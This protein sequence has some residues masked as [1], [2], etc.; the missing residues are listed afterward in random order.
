MP[1]QLHYRNTVISEIPE[2]WGKVLVDPQLVDIQS[3][4]ACAKSHAVPSGL[5]HLR[6]F[7]VTTNG[8][9]VITPDTVEIPSDFRQDLESY[10]LEAGDVLFNNTNSVELVGKTG[11]VRHAMKVAFSNHINRLRVKNSAQIDP[12]WLALALRNLQERGFFAA[13]C[14]KWIGQAGFNQTELAHVEIPLPNIEEQQRIVTRIE[15]LLA[16][17]REMRKLQGEITADTDILMSAMLAEVFPSLEQ[18]MPVGWMVRQVKDVAD[19]PQYGLTQSAKRD[20]VGPKFLR[21][22]DIQ[23]G[24]VNWDDVPYC[25][26]D[27][28]CLEKYQLK[29]GDIVFA[30]SGATTGKTYLVNDPPNEAVFASYLIRL[31]LH[32]QL[33]EYVYW[34][35]QSPAYW[36]QISPM[37]AAIPN[38]NATLLQEVKI[39]VPIDENE[40]RQIAAHLDLMKVEINEIRLLNEADEKYLNQLEQAIL[41]QAFRGEL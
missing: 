37:G 22:T 17:V 33:P 23:N 29:I 5:P 28:R 16:E 2:R 39:P 8:E 1:Q 13:H 27:H 3:G 4:F 32:E 11:I 18:P 12:R 7:N 30:R 24:S 21:I 9:V 36:R 38:M 15:A 40:Q 41:T 31:I 6:P 25:Q 14:R 35:F 19:K 20:P 34:F 26:C 10:Y